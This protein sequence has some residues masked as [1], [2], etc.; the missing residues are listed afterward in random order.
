MSAAKII[1]V[2]ITSAHYTI[3]RH[4]S[5][6]QNTEQ[7]DMMSISYVYQNLIIFSVTTKHLGNHLGACKLIIRNPV[8]GFE[9]KD[10]LT[11][12]KYA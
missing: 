3:L 9:Q 7:N 2:A 6:Y 11:S 4:S 8:E 12:V 1:G 5:G 10:T